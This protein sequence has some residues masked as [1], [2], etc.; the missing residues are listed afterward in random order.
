MVDGIQAV[1]LRQEVV[2][3]SGRRRAGVPLRAARRTELGGR[4]R[5]APAGVR[6]API[7]G[8]SGRR[9]GYAESSR[10]CHFRCS[11]CSLTAE[12]RAYA[13]RGVDD[14][15]RQIVAMGRREVICFQDNQFYGPDRSSFVERLALLRELR[16]AN[17]MLLLRPALE[18]LAHWNHL[19]FQ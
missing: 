19:R 17:E 7:A 16:A 2:E 13:T 15:R 1:A 5:P 18:L 12:G 14:L 8:W 4:R 6:H 10:N 11:Y 9:M 3:R